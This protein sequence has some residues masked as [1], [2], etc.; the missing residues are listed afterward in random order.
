MTQ[1]AERLT[2]H[3]ADGCVRGRTVGD[4]GVT[5]QP[6]SRWIVLDRA[7]AAERPELERAWTVLA[8]APRNV[9]LADARAA[10]DPHSG[11]VWQ[12]LCTE[13]D[14][15][16]NGCVHVFRHRQHPATRGREMAR[17]VADLP[18]PAADTRAC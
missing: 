1:R 10:E 11:E 2:L 15:S 4:L 18:D 14:A 6:P 7:D 16:G 3:D 17:I 5:A 12:Y 9:G 13:R 8:A